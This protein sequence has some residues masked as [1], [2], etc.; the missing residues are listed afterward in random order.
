MNTEK[1]IPHLFRTESRK[2]SAVLNK[3][4]GIDYMEIAEDIVSDTFLSAL[5]TWPYKG[6][7]DNPKAWLYAVAKNK[8][9]N[10]IARTSNFENNIT[11]EIFQNSE[12]STEIDLSERNISDSQLQMLF[13][14]C[15]PSISRESQIALALKTLCGFGIH[16]IATAFLS[17]KETINKRLFRAKEK[18]KSEK[19]KIEFPEESKITERLDTVLLTLYLL[20]NE[21]YYSENQDN[22]IRKELCSE[23]MMLLE[24]LLENYADKIPKIHAL[25]ALMCFHSSRLN[26]R[27]DENGQLILYQNQDENNW[28]R[29]LIDKGIVHLHLATKG[30][31][32]SKYHIEA[33]LAYW[34]THKQDT[35]EKW[36]HVLKLYNLLLF[37]EYS[38]IA[39]LNRT[40]ALS[41]VYGN[42]VA[43]V[44]AEKL[45]LETNPFYF[46][47]L[48]EF[49]KEKNK[50]I[51][52]EYLKKA[53]EISTS[54]AQKELI[55]SKIADL[56]KA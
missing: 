39:A 53:K 33:S 15:H 55:S 1:L 10:H 37:Q 7:P 46:S 8:T 17:N 11:L 4:F 47:L 29:S 54:K 20:F 25:Y 9:K 19:I 16:E 48:A 44:E 38:P 3:H 50:E 30:E 21:G 52:I 6:I 24:L 42:E 32:A 40:F 49:N 35:K 51:A 36:E 56:L 14:V 34:M 31:T 13:A 23:A 22:I 28:D 26:A 45:K 18:L 27:K 41:K 5:E 43:K 2:I 12:I